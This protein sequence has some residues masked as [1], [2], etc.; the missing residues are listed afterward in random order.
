MTPGIQ[1]VV[2]VAYHFLWVTFLLSMPM[3]LT[4]L[5]VGVIVSLAQTLTGV[6]EMTLAFVPKLLAVFAAI[7]IALPWMNRIMIEYVRNL[8]L[9]MGS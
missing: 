8:F 6:Q 2:D 9:L 1:D 4:A 7:A 5:V 3:L